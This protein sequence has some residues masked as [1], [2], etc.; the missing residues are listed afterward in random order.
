V[1]LEV[2][3]DVS[4]PNMHALRIRLVDPNGTQALLWDGPASPGRTFQ[5]H[6]VVDN[7][8]SRDDAI[9]G[10][11]SLLIDNVS[12]TQ[13]GLLKGWTLKVSSRWD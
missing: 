3:L 6:I 11:W 13:A 2:I 9:N 1:D 12:G 4:H 7:G 8:I 10:R 5:P